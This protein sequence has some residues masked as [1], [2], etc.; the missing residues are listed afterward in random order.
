MTVDVVL[1][2]AGGAVLALG[3]VSS[4]LKRV[5]LSAPLLALAGGVVLGPEVL[6]VI[7]PEA[8]GVERRVLEELARVTLS[9]SLVATGLQFTRADLRLNAAR[10]GLLL[11]VAMA[12]MW[13]V[14][15]L[16]AYLLLGVEA[17]VAI[18]IGGQPVETLNGHLDL[19]RP[20]PPRRDLVRGQS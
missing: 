14:T 18:L 20:L 8:L 7:D 15:S 5:W 4:L 19:T 1:V 9:V 2:V 10:A 6:H 3:L 17:W 12:G 13:V 11:T 16:G